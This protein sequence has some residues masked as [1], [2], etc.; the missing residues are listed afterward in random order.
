M[1]SVLSNRLSQRHPFDGVR[2]LDFERD[3]FDQRV[4]G[5]ASDRH[6]ARPDHRVGQLDKR[7]RRC[8]RSR[9]LVD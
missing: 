5:G 9:H 8:R 7:R 6:N 4:Q 2:L 1:G 3:R